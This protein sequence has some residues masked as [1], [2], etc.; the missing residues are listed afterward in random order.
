MERFCNCDLSRVGEWWSRDTR[1]GLSVKTVQLINNHTIKII[2]NLKNAY[3]T[4][5]RIVC[6]S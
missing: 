3:I 1:E 2:I 6:M 4:G 5:Y